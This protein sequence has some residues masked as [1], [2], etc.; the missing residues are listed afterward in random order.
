MI[1]PFTMLFA[2]AH[3]F[4]FEFLLAASCRIRLGNLYSFRQM[5]RTLYHLMCDS[6]C[7]DPFFLPEVVLHNSDFDAPSIA[8]VDVTTAI[9]NT[10][11]ATDRKDFHIA[12]L[13]PHRSPFF[14][15]IIAKNIETIDC[16]RAYCHTGS[17]YLYC[18]GH[19]KRQ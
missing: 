5:N 14:P 12:T 17:F 18:Q 15:I 8:I 9:Y 13:D 10:I 19:C 1:D 4:I 16:M 6:K 7:T 11:A 3:S 2:F